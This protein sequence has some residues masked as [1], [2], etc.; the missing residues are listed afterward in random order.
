MVEQA[1]PFCH[2]VIPAPELALAKMFYERVFGWRVQE[3]VPSATYWF[4]E[5]GNVGGAFNARRPP[6]TGSVVLVLRVEDLEEAVERVRR[7]GGTVT[8]EPG[9]IGEDKPGRDAYFLDPNGNE[10][11][12]YSGS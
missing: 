9:R 1:N 10:L 5:S 2:I 6:S 7:N 3:N 12:L 11:G 8:Q 4:F